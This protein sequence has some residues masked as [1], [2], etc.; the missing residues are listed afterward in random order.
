MA[1]GQFLCSSRTVPASEARR[2]KPLLVGYRRCMR[3][4]SVGFYVTHGISGRL[5]VPLLLL[6]NVWQKSLCDQGRVSELLSMHNVYSER[7]GFVI[8]STASDDP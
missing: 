2:D 8:A 7:M 6:D 3:R 4:S 1:A 5:V